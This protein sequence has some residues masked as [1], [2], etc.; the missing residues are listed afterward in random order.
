MAVDQ[1]PGHC[2]ISAAGVRAGYSLYSPFS[3][4][5]LGL[6][7]FSSTCMGF[8]RRWHKVY[9]HFKPDFWFWMLVIVAR[10]FC[11]AF[12]SLMFNKNP[13]FQFA[14]ALLVMFSCCKFA[15]PLK[16]HSSP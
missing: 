5:W 11:I 15:A 8:L 4:I 9:Y 16:L 3:P 1:R 13:T 14:M 6:L 2:S 10:K 7:L 12:T